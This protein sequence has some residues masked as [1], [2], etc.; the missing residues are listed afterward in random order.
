MKNNNYALIAG[1][2]GDILVSIQECY[3]KNYTKFIML[4]NQNDIE[5]FLMAQS[6]VEEVIKLPFNHEVMNEVNKGDKEFSDYCSSLFKKNI[7]AD[8]YFFDD[9][10]NTIRYDLYQNF[11]TDEK[12]MVW[13][14]EIVK[15]LPEDFI[16]FHP[17]SIGNSCPRKNHWK[18]WNSLIE[19]YV[20]KKHNIVLCGQSID[21]SHFDCY[22]NFYDL[23]NITES[24]QQIFAL[25]HYASRIIMTS[26]GLSFYCASN[27]FNS[28]VILNKTASNYFSGFNR[29][30]FSK[31]LTKIDFNCPLLEAISIIDNNKKQEDLYEIMA[32][33]PYLHRENT[34]SL[35]I[36]KNNS[37][38]E[39]IKHEEIESIYSE[40]GFDP[41]IFAHMILK[42]KRFIYHIQNYNE[43]EEF[44]ILQN[45]K[46]FIERHNRD[47]DFKFISKP[48]LNY[49]LL[50]SSSRIKQI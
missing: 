49:D 50:L 18:H 17:Y 26:N 21:F 23:T 10:N 43:D 44:K 14:K 16:L 22:E 1:A 19:H 31:N 4:S 47:I 24:F 38:C 48:L 36:D 12:S 46:Y 29:T 39:K 9:N 3:K 6:F 27:D 30:I 42:N 20:K 7:K 2:W 8:F 11:V 37:I 33:F 40:S 28:I 13:A 15:S 34:Y 25:C 41:L 5:N 32:C 35:L 45:V